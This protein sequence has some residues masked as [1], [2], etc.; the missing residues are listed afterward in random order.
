MQKGRK[1]MCA[2]AEQST[3]PSQHQ[4]TLL[5]ARL[6]L[7]AWPVAGYVDTDVRSASHS[8]PPWSLAL[9]NKSF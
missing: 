5:E 3:V 1:D 7:M 4:T 8:L 2:G 6:S 9:V